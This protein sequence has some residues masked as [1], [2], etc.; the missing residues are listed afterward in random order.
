[1]PSAQS[2]GSYPVEGLAASLRQPLSFGLTCSNCRPSPRLGRLLRFAIALEPGWRTSLTLI[3]RLFK[4]NAQRVTR[5]GVILTTAALGDAPRT[6][7]LA[8]W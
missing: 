6:R 7:I 8:V 3:I 4:Q 5:Q 1:M 2:G